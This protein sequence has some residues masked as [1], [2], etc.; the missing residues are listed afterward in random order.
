MDC[1]SP[2]RG[3]I[4]PIC[5]LSQLPC[6]LR[7]AKSKVG[8]LLWNPRWVS[9]QTAVGSGAPFWLQSHRV[10]FSLF[11]WKIEIWGIR[12]FPYWFFRAKWKLRSVQNQES[13]TLSGD[14]ADVGLACSTGHTHTVSVESFN[15]AE[16]QLIFDPQKMIS[17]IKTFF[18]SVGKKG[19]ERDQSEQNFGNWVSSFSFQC[20]GSRSDPRLTS[21]LLQ[22][23]YLRMGKAIAQGPVL[24]IHFEAQTAISPDLALPLTTQMP[25]WKVLY[26][27]SVFFICGLGID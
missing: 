17:G 8:A 12:V 2:S 10:S 27:A 16:Q 6:Y 26:W 18:F 14:K 13:A 3:L 5:F 23:W 11:Y 4:N 9:L 15:M 7:R 22:A 21:D 1:C 25:L 24:F 20:I 19:E